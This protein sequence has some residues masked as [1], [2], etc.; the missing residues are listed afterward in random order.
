MNEIDLSRILKLGRSFNELSNEFSLLARRLQALNPEEAGKLERLAGKLKEFANTILNK[1]IGVIVLD[2]EVLNAARRIEESTDRIKDAIRTINNIQRGLEIATGF[3]NLAS[4]IINGF[5]SS[6]L[7][8]T[9]NL[10]T[11]IDELIDTL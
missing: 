2:D 1:A 8:G 7:I 4:V 9:G 6:I 11:R 5:D 3:L 10:A